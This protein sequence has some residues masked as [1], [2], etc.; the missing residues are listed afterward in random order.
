[1]WK[2]KFIQRSTLVFGKGII[3][4]T[5]NTI[6]ISCN[7]SNLNVEQNK[8]LHYHSDDVLYNKRTL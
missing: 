8:Q 7:I 3:K 5:R 6:N 1:M 2:G 4:V